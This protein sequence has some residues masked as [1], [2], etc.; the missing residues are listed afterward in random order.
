MSGVILHSPNTPSCC[1][2][3]LKHRDNFTFYL[4]RESISVATCRV[5]L[6]IHT[7]EVGSSGVR[8]SLLGHRLS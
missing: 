8:D 2:A 6:L 1:G 3:Q 5:R 4:V 7:E